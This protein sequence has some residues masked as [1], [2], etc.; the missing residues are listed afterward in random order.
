M[1][2][3]TKP[4]RLLQHLFFAC[5]HRRLA[6]RIASPLV[7]TAT[8]RAPKSG[9]RT[10]A[11]AAPPCPHGRERREGAGLPRKR[12]DARQPPPPPPPLVSPAAAAK[13]CLRVGGGRGAGRG[14]REERGGR[15]ASGQPSAID[16]RPLRPGPARLPRPSAPLTPCRGR[17]LTRKVTAGPAQPPR[18]RA[19]P[20]PPRMRGEKMGDHFSLR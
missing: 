9:F 6:F 14:G 3:K 13:S 19:A 4:I 20:G 15:G 8:G 17:G 11:A 5:R 18:D 16:G 2:I 10:S 1:D 12:E 7:P